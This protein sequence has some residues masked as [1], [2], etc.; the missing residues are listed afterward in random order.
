MMMATIEN[1]PLPA[2]YAGWIACAAFT[3]WLFLLGKKAIREFRGEEP[4]PP[5]YELGRSMKELKRRV[6]TLERWREELIRKLD[7]D[8]GEILAAG[9]ERGGKI[10]ERINLV[11]AAVS[12][13][14]GRIEQLN[15]RHR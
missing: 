15:L 4:Q 11:L 5:N 9:E 13:L 8:K 3:L 14:E 1:F 10:H 7:E 12:K 2:Q 6:E